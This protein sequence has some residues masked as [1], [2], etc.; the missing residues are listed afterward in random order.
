MMPYTVLNKPKGRF[1][2]YLTSYHDYGVREHFKVCSNLKKKIIIHPKG[3][4]AHS[5]I[6]SRGDVHECMCD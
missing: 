4:N 5:T 2:N 6:Q 3:E 1:S